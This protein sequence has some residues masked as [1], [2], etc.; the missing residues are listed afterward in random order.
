ML[1]EYVENDHELFSVI[2]AKILDKGLVKEGDIVVITGSTQRSAGVTNTLQVYVVGDILLKG[3]AVGLNDASGRVFVVKEQDKDLSGF[4]PGDILAVS[5]TTTDIL[6][7]MRQCSGII[8][9]EDA[10][11]SGVMAAAYALDKPAVSNARGATAVLKTGSKIRIDIDK[12]FV[13]N[14]DV[15]STEQG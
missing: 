11:D 4:I 2:P 12:G 6:H 15:S 5:R 13:Y 10:K 9:E 3:K 1:N 8:T 14:S 7:L